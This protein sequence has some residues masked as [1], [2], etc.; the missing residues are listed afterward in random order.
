MST[1]G[2][3]L[4][5]LNVLAAIGLF[6]LA[7]K[8]YGE[9]RQARYAVFRHEMFLNG[10]PTDKEE[11]PPGRPGDPI[12]ET[13]APDSVL[14]DVFQGNTG[15]GDL[16]GEEVRTV[17]EELDRVQK[18]VRSNVFN[19]GDD[20]HKRQ[21]LMGY[22]LL[23]AN[24]SGEREELR[25]KIATGPIEDA[26][27]ELDKR[28]EAAR[29][30]SATT[31][32]PSRAII[33]LAAARLLVNLS[34]EDKWLERVRVVVGI[35]ALAQGIDESARHVEQMIA[36]VKDAITR[37]QGEFVGRYRELLQQLRLDGENIYQAG[38]RLAEQQTVVADRNLE[39][40]QRDSEVK[41]NQTR[42]AELTAETNKEVGRLEAIQ[43]DLFAV[44]QR[45][46]V[47][48]DSSRSLEEQL[49]KRAGSKP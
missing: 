20:D 22:L 12:A 6:I 13:L 43:R 37:D 2:K 25:T 24:D 7:G 19:A 3:I 27:A 28:F 36:D 26:F 42:L 30:L 1:L 38:Q 17:L 14:K 44:Q 5:F 34:F 39:L 48:L 33:R 32:Q 35:E 9:F 16:G 45:L 40:A 29:K 41:H 11:F 47:A 23:Q 46:S 15:G 8:D 21:K 10:L 31:G 18:K 49:Q 4:L